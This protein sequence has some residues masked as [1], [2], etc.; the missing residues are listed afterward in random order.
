MA[1]TL[2]DVAQ[3]VHTATCVSLMFVLETGQHTLSLTRYLSTSPLSDLAHLA[4]NT[5]YK[6][7]M[8]WSTDAADQVVFSAFLCLAHLVHTTL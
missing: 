8:C 5:I 1:H 2:S 7:L 4:H 3:L 6:S